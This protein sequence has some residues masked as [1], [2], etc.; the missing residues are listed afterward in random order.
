MTY[1]DPRTP[2]DYD[3]EL[4]RN[5]PRY[6]N[7]E[8]A[9]GFSG[10]AL[11]A[12]VIAAVLVIGAL[13]YAMSDRTSTTATGPNTTTSAPSTTGQGERTTVNPG[14]QQNVPNPSPPAN[15]PATRQ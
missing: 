10:G 5:P 11:A 12:A 15:A 14:S 6:R 7:T 4:G 8:P 1:N 9:S 13:I 3:T 2:R